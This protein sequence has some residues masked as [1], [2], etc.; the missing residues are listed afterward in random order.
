MVKNGDVVEGISL[1]RSGSTAFRV[2]GT[3]LWMPHH[4]ALLAAACE[5]AEQLEEPLT[6]LDEA[7]QIVEG[8]GERCL[9]AEL[10]RHKGELLLR[11]GHP[12]PPRNCI[13]KP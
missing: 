13:E 5:I 8:T 2:T 10:N 1:L 7:L 12:R 6:L 9:A 3:E 4:I 11:Q